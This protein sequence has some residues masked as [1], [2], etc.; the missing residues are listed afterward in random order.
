MKPES[1]TK[2]EAETVTYDLTA[3]TAGSCFSALSGC[4]RPG[5]GRIVES[6]TELAEAVFDDGVC[7]GSRFVLILVIEGRSFFAE[8]LR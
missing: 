8:L 4:I 5:G 2:A 3:Q 6:R 1:V 7:G